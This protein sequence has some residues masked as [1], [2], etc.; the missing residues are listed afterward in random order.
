MKQKC[1]EFYCM[2]KKR[3]I[4]MG[5]CCKECKEIELPEKYDGRICVYEK[6]VREYTREV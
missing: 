2:K 5:W 6:T 4:G 3:N 1:Y